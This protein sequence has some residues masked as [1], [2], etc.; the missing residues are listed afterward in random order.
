MSALAH[1]DYYYRHRSGFIFGTR[2][3][4]APTV[5]VGDSFNFNEDTDGVT[6]PSDFTLFGE[7]DIELAFETK[8]VRAAI[9]GS[10]SLDALSDAESDQADQIAAEAEVRIRLKATD[11]LIGM[12]VNIDEPGGF[13]FDDGK[14]WSFRIGF[15]TPTQ[16]RLPE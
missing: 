10:Y 14:V 13:S 15:A 2:L 3:V 1:F 6:E 8:P 9:R 4:A 7:G 16:L 11:L 5:R 12:M